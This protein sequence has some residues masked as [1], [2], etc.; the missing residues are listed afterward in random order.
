MNEITPYSFLFDLVS[1][2]LSISIPELFYLL[3]LLFREGWL[4]YFVVIVIVRNGEP[5]NE[6]WSGGKLTQI[7]YV[8]LIFCKDLIYFCRTTIIFW[9]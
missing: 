4:L 3:L 5:N 1:F 7:S 9:F 8:I 2:L 6:L